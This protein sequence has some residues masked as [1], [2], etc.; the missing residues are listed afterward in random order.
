MAS[1]IKGQLLKLE[2]LS[3]ELGGKKILQNINLN[4]REGEM[5]GIVGVSGAGKTTL[6]NAIIGYYPITSGRVMYGSKI[7]GKFVP[8]MENPESY[9]RLFGFSTQDPSFYPELTVSENLNYFAGLYNLGKSIKEQNIK[10]ALE[11]VELH[12]FVSMPGKNL[13][14][15][16]KK[17]LD[18]ACA[19]VH[20]PKILILDE[21]TA[22]MDPILRVQ[23]WD[24]MENINRR[25]T[26]IIVA[27]HFLSELEHFCDRIVFLHTRKVAFFGTTSE[28]RQFHSKIKEIQIITRDGKYD[29]VLKKILGLPFIEV[30]HSNSRKNRIILQA[31]QQEHIIN[32]ALS[33][34]L[35]NEDIENL[36]IRNP[37]MD[38]LFKMFLDK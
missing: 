15:G 16:M 12:D 6:L 33:R 8:G 20:N 10:K 24:V 4:I 37:S 31:K 26:T 13:S 5:L 35:T 18:I 11:L 3:V 28:F 32:N 36:E 17:R 38:T 14:G 25:G 19:I 34:V 2:N 30:K 23:M 9:K 27:S 21:P 1:E 22:D 7:A 29:A